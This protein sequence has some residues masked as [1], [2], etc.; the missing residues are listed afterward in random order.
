M[1]PPSATITQE[2]TT[3][4]N[5]TGRL[6]DAIAIGIPKF[7]A[8][9]IREANFQTPPGSQRNDSEVRKARTPLK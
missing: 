2:K 6:I 4:V 8:A 7:C 1:I 5:S 3:V 9:S